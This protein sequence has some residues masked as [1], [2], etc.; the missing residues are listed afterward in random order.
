MSKNFRFVLFFTAIT[1]FVT[2]NELHYGPKSSS[3]QEL[4][5]GIITITQ[6]EIRANTHVGPKFLLTIMSQLWF[7]SSLS[8]LWLMSKYGHCQVACGHGTCHPL[9]TCLI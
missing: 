2:P 8:Q 5:N 7:F 4:S 3:E 1:F 6:V 9:N